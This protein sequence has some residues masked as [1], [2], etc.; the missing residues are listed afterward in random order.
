MPMRP[1]WSAWRSMTRVRW[2]TV[3]NPAVM[4]HLYL[5]IVN[6]P[7]PF[8]DGS[9]VRKH[10]KDNNR[11]GFYLSPKQ[12]IKPKI[13]ES[14]FHTVLTKHGSHS[15]WTCLPPLNEVL[16]PAGRGTPPKLESCTR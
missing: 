8:E 15:L 2:P 9:H 4:S 10:P 5:R 11:G 7:C 3:P 14:D 13:V 12:R 1:G 6:P 16:H